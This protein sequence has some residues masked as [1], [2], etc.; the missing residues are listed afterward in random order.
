MGHLSYTCDDGCGRV[1]K[2]AGYVG[3]FSSAGGEDTLTCTICE[4]QEDGMV[5]SRYSED[6]LH[7]LSAVGTPNPAVDDRKLLPEE[8]YGQLVDSGQK[9]YYHVAEEKQAA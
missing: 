3:Y 1:S 9:V 5:F 7:I 4:L 2:N 6:G 8:Y